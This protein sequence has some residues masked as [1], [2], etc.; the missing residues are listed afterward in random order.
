[1][2]MTTLDAFERIGART[3]HKQRRAVKKH[4][5]RLEYLNRR[6]KRF[7]GNKHRNPK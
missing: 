1:M 3:T 2:Q 7:K 5:D 4:A 6:N